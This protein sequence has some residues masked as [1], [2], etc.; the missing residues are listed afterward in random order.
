MEELNK[1]L[2]KDLKWKLFENN[3]KNKSPK[4]NTTKV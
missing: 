2:P 4:Q 1:S 3:S